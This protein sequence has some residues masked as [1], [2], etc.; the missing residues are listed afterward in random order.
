[1]H[2]WASQQWHPIEERVPHAIKALVK[3]IVRKERS[4]LLLLL[5][6]AALCLS[7]HG[8]Y[9]DEPKPDLALYYGFG[10]LEIFKLEQRSGN[11]LAADV[12]GD[13]RLDLIL[14]DNSHSRIDV[15]QQR[16]NPPAGDDATSGAESGV[17]S[18]KDDWRFEH[19]KIP[20]DKE[21]G[22]LATG[23]FD[24][25]GRVDL[26]YFGRPDGLI[27]LFQ[28]ESG[29][30]TRTERHRL[31]DV[32]AT[33]WIMTS[34]DLNNDQR[35][36][37]VVVGE[38][39]TF[40]LHGRDGGKPSRPQRIMNTS[41]ELSLVQIAD[42]DGDDRSDLCYVGS[43]GNS[44]TF[45]VRL[46]GDDG[47]LGPELQFDLDEPLGITLA[48]VDGKP[49]HEILSVDSRT[50]HV[51][52]RRLLDAQPDATD[53]RGRLVQYGFGKRNSSDK[54]DLATGDVDGDGLTDVV[55]T[56]PDAARVIVFRQHAGRGLDLGSP[57]PG[58]LQAE[59]VRVADLDGDGQDEVVTL[60]PEERTLGLSQFREGR[61]TFPQALPVSA[62]PIALELAD[63]DGNGQLEI[64]FISQEG[65]R[66]SAKYALFALTRNGAD[67]SPF[68]FGDDVRMELKLSAPPKRLV[69]LD[70]DRNGRPDFL[71]FPEFNRGVP[72]LLVMDDS[73]RLRD[74]KAES[75]IR[76]GETAAGAVFVG[77]NDQPPLLVAQRQ[78]ARSLRLQNDRQWKV[79]DQYNAPESGARIVGVAAINLDNTPGDEIALVDTGVKRLRLMRL[80]ESGV[81]RPWREV[82]IGDFPFQSTRVADLNSDGGD[83][84]LLFGSG[85]FA[86][87]YANQGAL[88][89]EE[90][91][92]FETKLEKVYFSDAVAGDLNSDGLSDLAVVDIRS[93][94]I[95][96]LHFDGK[97][98]L[99]HALH[100]K[101]FE[102]KSFNRED[103]QSGQPRE[104]LIADVTGDGRADLVLLTHD[105]L[106]LYP[107]DDG[108]SAETG[109]V[110]GE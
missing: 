98:R 13:G 6:V 110:A 46:Q 10:G 51:K 19:R 90:V 56:D 77:D 25:D 1:M 62:E 55:V 12:N 93:H 49:G 81:Y 11:M 104:A 14:A 75:G 17:N 50:R 72:T 33:P 52:I 73:G 82:E 44:R 27:I 78:F 84:L 29:G 80:D 76:L 108:K 79:I 101:V 39:E 109:P 96:L 89:L 87:L 38:H 95:E 92:S 26:A 37:L 61:L 70:A 5:C 102:E 40:V 86:V 63:L 88:K 71:A 69:R 99:Q 42:L 4:Q 107:Q 31:P 22:G 28:T 97:S 41:S 74:T 94:Y 47:R 59:H 100:F 83:D 66:R 68:H 30:W 60:S 106:L 54:R 85:R 16:A 2:C 53:A 58:L 43:D 35:S 32:A 8:I 15:L 3:I 67:W 21:I 64:L 105:R 34:G 45:S 36:D 91:A 18:V 7:C 9:A 103:G 23:D 24:G 65:S 48:D 57:F 20:V